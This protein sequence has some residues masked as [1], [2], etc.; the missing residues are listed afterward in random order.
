MW[1]D[2]CNAC[3]ETCVDEIPRQ[4]PRRG[5]RAPKPIPVERPDF[6]R[7]VGVNLQFIST[8]CG[9][10]PWWHITC[11]YP[12][13]VG[14]CVAVEHVATEFNLN[15]IAIFLDEHPWDNSQNWSD[16]RP[17]FESPFVDTIMVQ[18]L[19]WGVT[20][21]A[22]GA[23]YREVREAGNTLS[24]YPTDDVPEYECS[25]LWGESLEGCL[26]RHQNVFEGFYQNYPDEDVDVIVTSSENDW[27]IFGSGCRSVDE[28]N[29]FPGFWALEACN[30]GTG[31]FED[32]MYIG[33]TDEDGNVDC[34]T[35]ACN[36]L[37]WERRD[38]MIR[39]LTERQRAAERARARHP[40]AKLRVWHNV[41]INFLGNEDWQFITVVRDVLPYVPQVDSV[42]ISL[43][44]MSGGPEWAIAYVQAHTGLPA[45]RIFIG[46]IGEKDHANQYD[47]I[48]NWTDKA[49]EMGVRLSFV[50]D[51]EYSEN[52][53]NSSWTIID[54]ETWE[55]FPGM[56]AVRDLN[57]KWRN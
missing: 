5:R 18:L 10:A 17:V 56:E 30:D 11:E 53:H 55:W 21:T 4:P 54:R 15:A 12:D 9:P 22:C 47:R 6:Q 40:D 14:S 23:G 7:S 49:F 42:S 36:Q 32:K 48:Y 19:Y 28:C 3:W 44:A 34:Y 2:A 57:E 8:Q 1:P 52:T 31:A 45:H 16:V 51:L 13:A 43:Y 20:G 38:W 41:E 26:D 35:V 29:L 50:W 46:E 33:A 27:D 24:E 25:G 37:R 39:R